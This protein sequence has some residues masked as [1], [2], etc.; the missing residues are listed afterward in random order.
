MESAIDKHLMC[1]RSRDRRIDDSY[2]PPYPAWVARADGSVKQ[3]VMGYFGVQ[4]FGEG[5]LA[6]ACAALRQIAQSFGLDDGPRH[7]DF[8]HYIDAKG[9][10][11]MVVIGYWED[12][13][14]FERWESSSAVS[15]WWLSEEL[16]RDGLGYFRETLT[17]GVERFE[18][19]YTLPEY[20]EGIGVVMG[21]SSAEIQEHGY[22]GSM[23][24]RIPLSQTDRM[25]PSGQLETSAQAAHRVVIQGHENLTIIRSGQD[26]SETEG[27]ERELYLNQMEPVLR[28]GMDFLR[29]DGLS[30]GCYSNRFMQHIDANGRPQEKAVSVSY[31]RSLAHLER[32]SESHPSHIEIFGTFMRMVQELQGEVKWKG[33]HEVSVL[34]AEDQRYEYINCHPDTGLMRSV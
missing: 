12:P 29:D 13:T 2:A 31:W 34:R 1:P 28:A 5:C 7:H 22:W 10:D 33:Y 3:V 15:Q 25:S 18:T 27:K 30:V 6:A 23:R 8:A 24:D 32:W 14:A 4:S 21:T 11:N 17:P 26:W 16:G 20:M 9:Y 19:L